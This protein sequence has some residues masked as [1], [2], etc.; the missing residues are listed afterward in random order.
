MDRVSIECLADLIYLLQ[1]V[2][3]EGPRRLPAL[4]EFRNYVFGQEAVLGAN[5][6][7]WDILNELA[8][9]LEFYVPDP[10]DRREDPSYF[11]EERLEREVLEALTKLA[12]TAT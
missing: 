2:R 5:G 4:S 12:N 9:D 7:Q 11:G 8:H 10:S 1:E 3:L 6:R